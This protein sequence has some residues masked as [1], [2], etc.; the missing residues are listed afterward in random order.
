[1]LK[2]RNGHSRQETVCYLTIADDEFAYSSKSQNMGIFEL[3]ATSF[4]QLLAVT[5]IV[6]YIYGEVW[7]VLTERIF[8]G[9]WKWHVMTWLIC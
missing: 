9:Q 6:S 2:G 8:S 3:K 7:I 5:G 1:M 4:W